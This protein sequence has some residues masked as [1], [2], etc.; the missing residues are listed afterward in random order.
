MAQISMRAFTVFSRLVGIFLARDI[1]NTASKLAR[2][3]AEI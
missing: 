2:R 3:I 1:A